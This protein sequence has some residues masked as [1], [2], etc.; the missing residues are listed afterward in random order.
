MTKENGWARLYLSTALIDLYQHKSAG[1]LAD[2]GG[3]GAAGVGGG[4]GDW[5]SSGKAE[6]EVGGAV[7]GGKLC[8]V[9]EQ[10]GLR[11]VASE[12][13]RFFYPGGRGGRKD[14]I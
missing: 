7:P 4:G 12:P 1:D 13:R 10:A 5:S 14:W 2:L 3:A 9:R 11:C 8:R 6:G